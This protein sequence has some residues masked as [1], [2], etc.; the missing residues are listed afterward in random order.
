MNDIIGL[1]I[2]MFRIYNRIIAKEEVNI[3]S[4]E[5]QGID[6]LNRDAVMEDLFCI[7][8]SASKNQAYC[9][10]AIMIMSYTLKIAKR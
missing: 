2:Y 10:F 4:S 5:N 1:E 3:V 9:P 8:Q 6:I 7:V